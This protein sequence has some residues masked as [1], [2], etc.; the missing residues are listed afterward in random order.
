MLLI[1]SNDYVCDQ[2]KLGKVGVSDTEQQGK[3]A[4]FA[5][6]LLHLLLEIHKLLVW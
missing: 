6:L 4:A 2:N 5:V 3:K 1:W